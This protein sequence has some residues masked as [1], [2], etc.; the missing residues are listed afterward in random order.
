MKFCDL[1]KY[2]TNR[3][4]HTRMHSRATKA[5]YCLHKTKYVK[6][7]FTNLSTRWYVCDL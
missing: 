7:A 5:S 6:D 3:N 2:I 4:R 1:R